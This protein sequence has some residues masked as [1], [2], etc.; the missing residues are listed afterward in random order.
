MNDAERQT[1]HEPDCHS[2]DVFEHSD[3]CVEL[4]EAHYP[5]EVCF[6][7]PCSDCGKGAGRDYTPEAIATYYDRL[8][9]K[10]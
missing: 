3:E 4:K 9:G 2:V 1:P 5:T 10:A 8:E 6:C 7:S